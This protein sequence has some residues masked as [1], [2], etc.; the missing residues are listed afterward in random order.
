M[1]NSPEAAKVHSPVT[2]TV[3]T[4][5]WPEAVRVS[6]FKMP[7][8][9]EKELSHWNKSN[10]IWMGSLRLKG[11][12]LYKSYIAILSQDPVLYLYRKKEPTL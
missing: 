3:E 2:P 12:I 7:E 11:T 1:Y 6:E 10:T 8:A 5:K 4:E 9:A